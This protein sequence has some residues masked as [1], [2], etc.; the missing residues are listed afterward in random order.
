MS[1][2]S[3]VKT[4]RKNWHFEAFEF[5]FLWPYVQLCFRCFRWCYRP[6]KTDT[7]CKFF[8]AH[9]L[10]DSCSWEIIKS[11]LL[12]I[13]MQNYWSYLTIRSLR[14]NDQVSTQ[15]FN[16]EK[17]YCKREQYIYHYLLIS[18]RQLDFGSQLGFFNSK[19]S[20]FF[21]SFFVSYMTWFRHLC[22]NTQISN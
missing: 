22:F 21:V 19:H 10:V 16:E 4:T 11:V 3:L 18:V 12:Q 17:R 7:K 15:Y 5:D 6:K 13:I 9:S 8:T 20:Q 14:F 1:S 2:I